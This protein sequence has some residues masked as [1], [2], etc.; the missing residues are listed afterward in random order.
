[1]ACSRS[2]GYYC[3][4]QEQHR[5]IDLIKVMNQQITFQRETEAGYGAGKSMHSTVQ[6]GEVV[7][8]FLLL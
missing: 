2:K 5:L 3:F 8:H 7:K 6:K 1:M 4:P